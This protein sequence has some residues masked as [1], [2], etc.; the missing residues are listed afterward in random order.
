ML[1]HDETHLISQVGCTPVLLE[2]IEIATCIFTCECCVEWQATFL[3]PLHKLLAML[4]NQPDLQ[5]IF[6]V[7]IHGALQDDPLFDM[8]TNN[9]EVSFELLFSVSE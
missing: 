7:G 9:P 2:T 6:M 3:D 1:T 8:P 4:Y 5:M